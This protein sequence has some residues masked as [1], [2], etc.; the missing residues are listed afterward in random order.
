[1]KDRMYMEDIVRSINTE[2]TE[3][4]G[5]T[6]IVVWGLGEFAEKIAAYTELLNYNVLFFV[7]ENRE[8]SFLG[9]T[10]D[11]PKNILWNTID[12]VL[13]LSFNKY[14]EIRE[15]LHAEYKYS[16]EIIRLQKF[17][18]S[19]E[20]YKYDSRSVSLIEQQYRNELMRNQVFCDIHKGKRCYILG[21][22]PSLKQFDLNKIN[23]EVVFAVNEFYLLGNVV[24]INYYVAADPYYWDAKV[25]SDTKGRFFDGIKELEKNNPNIKYWFPVQFCDVMKSIGIQWNNLFYFFPGRHWDRRIDYNIDLTKRIMVR[26]SVIQYCIQMAVYMGIKEVFLLGC[27]ET[28]IISLLNDYLD[29]SGYEYAYSISEDDMKSFRNFFN[30]ISIYNHLYGFSN[31]LKGYGEM[32]ELCFNNGIK[33]YTCAKR[34]LVKDV[35]YFDYR[36]LF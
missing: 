17:N 36:E 2:L 18:D 4:N 9:R 21:G 12:A 35:P 7:D 8:G 5:K 20:F 19:K 30:E 32:Q 29:D 23:D 33:L 28:R 15:K 6:R 3:L 1:M 24:N 16:G 10:I 14:V 22:G 26:W 11:K 27:E 34:T 31:I 13:I 25:I